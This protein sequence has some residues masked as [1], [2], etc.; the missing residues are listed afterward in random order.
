MVINRL[1][2]SSGSESKKQ[3]YDSNYKLVKNNY[4]M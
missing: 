4:N 1:T 2:K 3:I